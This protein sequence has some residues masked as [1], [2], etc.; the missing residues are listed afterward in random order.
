MLN[1]QIG[2]TNLSNTI[3]LRLLFQTDQSQDD[4]ENLGLC[5]AFRI[6]IRTLYQL[7]KLSSLLVISN[8]HLQNAKINH[9]ENQFFHRLPQVYL[10]FPFF[11]KIYNTYMNPRFKDLS[12]LIF[13]QE[14][15]IHLV[16]RSE[17]EE[18]Q[19]LRGDK[20]RLKFSPDFEFLLNILT[21]YVGKHFANFDGSA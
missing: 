7:F 5:Y 20:S 6:K 12:M 21:H 16:K 15:L 13:C 8:Y 17:N 10:S 1:S 18:M 3:S 4:Q 19:N 14:G 2:Y 9:G 11:L